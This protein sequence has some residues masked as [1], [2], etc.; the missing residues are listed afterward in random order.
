MCGFDLKKKKKK[1]TRLRLL[2]KKTT[3]F[4]YTPVFV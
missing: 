1:E 4:I 2:C 3:L